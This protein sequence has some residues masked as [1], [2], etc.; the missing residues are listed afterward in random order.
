MSIDEAIKH[1]REVA[2]CCKSEISTFPNPE[3]YEEYCNGELE[4][5]AD[6][7]EQLAKWLEEL[8]SYQQLDLDIPQHFTKEQ[9]DWIKKYCIQ[10]NKKFYQQ[11]IDDFA[12]KLK[13]KISNNIM[14]Q[15]FGLRGKDI[16]YL[17]DETL[18]ELKAGVNNG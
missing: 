10:K 15:T 7:H 4:K 8:K 9:S 17:I 16:F 1:A 11:A 5:C 6:E 3:P 12:N 13:E 2:D 14:A 18:N